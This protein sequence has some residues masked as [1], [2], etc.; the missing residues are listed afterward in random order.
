MDLRNK[1][2]LAAKILDVGITRVWLDP[3]KKQEIKEAITREDLKRLISKGI[4]LVKQKK[5]VSRGRV[6]RLLLQKRKGRRHGI[7]SRKGK[8][9]ARAGKKELWVVKIRLYRSLFNSLLE[10]QLVTKQTYRDLRNKA[11]GGYFR[12]RRHILLYLTEN[13]LWVKKK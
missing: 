1:K 8:H 6:R 5:G 3:N 12:S 13:A 10:K 11:K 7:G 9:T 4:I 2:E